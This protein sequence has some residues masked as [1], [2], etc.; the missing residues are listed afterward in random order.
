MWQLKENYNESQKR[1]KVHY[2]FCDTE[3]HAVV[4]TSDHPTVIP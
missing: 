3:M 1:L 4:N 2:I